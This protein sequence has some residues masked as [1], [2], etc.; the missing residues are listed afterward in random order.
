M[1]IYGLDID[2]NCIEIAEANSKRAGT[3]GWV[4]L[5]VGDAA[6]FVSP[7]PGA[8]GTIVCNPPYGERMM[9]KESVAKLERDVGKALAEAIPAW[10]MYFISSDEQFESNFGRRADKKRT[11]YNG[12]IK[13]LFYQYYKREK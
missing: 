3:R 1:G 8:R 12:M 10:Q 2:K 9:E 7:V 11:L 4:N 6:K 13:C 5:R